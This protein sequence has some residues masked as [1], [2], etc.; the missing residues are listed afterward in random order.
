MTN[1]SNTSNY[2]AK[3]LQTNTLHID[4]TN[5]HSLKLIAHSARRVVAIY[6]FNELD[7]IRMCYNT[8]CNQNKI[9]VEHK[10]ERNN[11]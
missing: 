11:D 6:S 10:N 1:I 8:D 9:R 2:K 7:T 4:Q 3:Y 5:T